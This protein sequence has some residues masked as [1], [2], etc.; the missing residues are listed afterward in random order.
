MRAFRVPPP[1]WDVAGTR[2]WLEKNTAEKKLRILV[3][4]NCMQT[5]TDE[6]ILELTTFVEHVRISFSRIVPEGWEVLA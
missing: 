1:P 2:V 6:Q 5:M 4:A 3:P